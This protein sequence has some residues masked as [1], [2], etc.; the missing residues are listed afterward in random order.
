MGGMWLCGV[1]EGL[2]GLYDE[3][4]MTFFASYIEE[5]ETM[6]RKER[7]QTGVSLERSREIP[8]FCQLVILTSFPP[9]K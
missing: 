5:A 2:L 7:V 1:R 3:S 4:Y 6:V 8:V 9:H